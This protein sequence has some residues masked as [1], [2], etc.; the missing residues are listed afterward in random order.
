MYLWFPKKVLSP[1]ITTH[2]RL[3]KYDCTVYFEKIISEFLQGYPYACE[4]MGDELP[5]KFGL[6]LETTVMTYIDHIYDRKI[7]ESLTGLIT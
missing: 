6:W 2:S 1:V 7:Y 5:Q 3:L 4:K